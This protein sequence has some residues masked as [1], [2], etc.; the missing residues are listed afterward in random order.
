MLPRHAGAAVTIDIDTAKWSHSDW[1]AIETRS[2]I[3][4]LEWCG[5]NKSVYVIKTRR[6]N[7]LS[8]LSE[9]VC[10][11][12]Y[13]CTCLWVCI[14]ICICVYVYVYVYVYVW[15]SLTRRRDSVTIG[16]VFH[17]ECFYLFLVL[18][19]LS[20]ADFYIILGPEKANCGGS[21]CIIGIDYK[22]KINRVL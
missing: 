15:G 21:K 16:D 8:F 11:C 18:F 12:V 4:K 10:V 5:Q 14:C 13:V 17:Q 7:I 1:D 19:L 3:M 9:C 22:H 20:I 6:Q 2:H